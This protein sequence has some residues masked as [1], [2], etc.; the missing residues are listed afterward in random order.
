MDS[1]TKRVW[2]DGVEGLD[3]AVA[4]SSVLLQCRSR[5]YSK[6][7]KCPATDRSMLRNSVEWRSASGVVAPDTNCDISRADRDRRRWDSRVREATE[8][9]R[10]ILGE[11]E[12]VWGKFQFHFFDNPKT[13]PGADYIL[14][15]LNTLQGPWPTTQHGPRPTLKRLQA[16]N[17][18]DPSQCLAHRRDIP[19]LG[20]SLPI[21]HLFSPFL[22]TEFLLPWI[23]K[24][25]SNGAALVSLVC[26][27]IML[28]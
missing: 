27:G 20:G 11:E 4:A 3:G 1:S 5:I 19:V 18:P 23:R 25:V 12:E 6:S 22:V 7:S 24:V 16:V 26:L 21:P 10:E 13:P 2:A 28:D 9:E 15:H 17:L 14:S 8:R